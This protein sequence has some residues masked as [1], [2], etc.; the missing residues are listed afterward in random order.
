MCGKE[1]VQK[2]CEYEGAKTEQ[3][4]EET[5]KEKVKKRI[6]MKGKCFGQLELNKRFYSSP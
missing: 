2:G 5:R 6:T 3:R 1:Q 4:A